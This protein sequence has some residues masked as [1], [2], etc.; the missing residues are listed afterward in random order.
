MYRRY[1]ITHLLQVATGLIELLL[2]NNPDW[3]CIVLFS[4]GLFSSGP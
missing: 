3:Q 2:Q 4:P 1:L